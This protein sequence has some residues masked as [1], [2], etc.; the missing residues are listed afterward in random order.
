MK[1]MQEWQSVQDAKQR[2]NCENMPTDLQYGK[3]AKRLEAKVEVILWEI[4][5]E[6]EKEKHTRDIYN[7]SDVST[8]YHD[9]CRWRIWWLVITRYDSNC[10]QVDCQLVI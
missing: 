5:T 6:S 8:R 4:S 3:M 10:A 7:D 1:F 9:T 2:K